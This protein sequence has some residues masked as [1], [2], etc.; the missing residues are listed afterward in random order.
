M[1]NASA[2]VFTQG[3]GMTKL[4]INPDDLLITAGELGEAYRESQATLIRVDKAVAALENKWE[5]ASR[6]A[7][8]RNYKD[9]RT[10]MAGMAVLLRQ[11]SREMTVMAEMF[12]KTESPQ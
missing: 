9:W 1:G 12:Q 7:F 2:G 5:G 4:K 11:V 10:A 8:Y 3:D 6:Q